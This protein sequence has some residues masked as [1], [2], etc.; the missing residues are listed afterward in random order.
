MKKVFQFGNVLITATYTENSTEPENW[1][2]K[3]DFRPLYFVTIREAGNKKRHSVKAWGNLMN[4]P[5]AQHQ[6]LAGL[7][8]DEHLREIGSFQDFCGDYGYNTDSI[9]AL[10]V[11][12]QLKTSWSGGYWLNLC[13]D[14]PEF[15][16]WENSGD[17]LANFLNPL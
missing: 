15:K 12:K 5:D 9:K 10:K 11:Y 14:S 8:L 6:D 1:G 17:D 2:K 13:K 3:G 7:V 16:K 4:N